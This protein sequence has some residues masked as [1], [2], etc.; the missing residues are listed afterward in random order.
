MVESRIF[1]AGS[2]PPILAAVAIW[3]PNLVARL[4]LIAS[5]LAL[6]CRIFCHLLCPL[7]HCAEVEKPRVDNLRNDMAAVVCVVPGSCVMSNKVK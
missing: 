2:A 4:P 3:F 5:C 6:V 1:P 7:R